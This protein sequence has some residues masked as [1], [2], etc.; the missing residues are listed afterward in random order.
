M[1]RDDEFEELR[2][3]FA[4]DLAEKIKELQKAVAN[5]DHDVI[6]KISHQIGGSAKSFGYPE[7]SELAHEL[8]RSARG[9]S[10]EDAAVLV[11]KMSEAFVL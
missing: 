4:E 3:L 1:S 9:I 5:S 6:C 11:K 7:V 8:E 2:S 10:L